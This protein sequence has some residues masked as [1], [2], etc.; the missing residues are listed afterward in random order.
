MVDVV[1]ETQRRV[2][3]IEELRREDQRAHVEAI[4]R[5][6]EMIVKQE[7]MIERMRE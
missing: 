7:M 3:E 6:E 4:R 1:G 5:M 2:R